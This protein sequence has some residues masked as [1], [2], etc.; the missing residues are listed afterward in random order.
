QPLPLDRDPTLLRGLIFLGSFA[1][2]SP[3]YRAYAA[4]NAIPLY[5]FVDRGNVLLQM[6][7]ADQTEA[8]A[9]F[10]PAAYQA[11]RSDLDLGRLKVLD[12]R[13]PL[14]DGI[15]VTSDG[16]LGWSGGNIG[17]ETVVTQRGF[18]TVLAEDGTGANAA[19]LEA[20]YGQG[21]FIVTAMAFDKALGTSPVPVPFGAPIGSAEARD[22]FNRRFFANLYQHVKSVCRRQARP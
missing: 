11:R 21:R 17:W 1:S 15:D 4:A 2:E 3:V 20:P 12:P 8:M 14:L 9:P 10:Y 13:H 22:A 7:Q 16:Y 19:L 6:T 5:N 18:A